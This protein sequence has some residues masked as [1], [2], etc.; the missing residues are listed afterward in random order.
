MSERRL[1]KTEVL[2]IHEAAISRFGGLSG[3]RDEGLLESALAQPHQT[4]GG[5]ELYP[6]VEEK[7]ARYAYG[8]CRNHPFLDG[9][10]RVATA[11]LGVYLRLE[12][13]IFRPS[14]EALLSIMR[15]VAD[16][17]VDYDRLLDWV[18]LESSQPKE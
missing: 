17:S 8:I 4:F 10:K 2:A 13:R 12:N 14:H 11:C 7:A 5:V 16:G 3:M 6:T 15:G 9:N 1:L 18:R